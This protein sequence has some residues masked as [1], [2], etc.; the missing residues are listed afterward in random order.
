MGRSGRKQN[1]A[2]CNGQERIICVC[3][4][5]TDSFTRELVSPFDHPVRVKSVRSLLKQ[6]KKKKKK[7]AGKGGFVDWH[8]NK[9][10]EDANTDDET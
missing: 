6:K 2:G 1:P 5:S 3:S 10:E 8:A 4:V 9:E 7:K